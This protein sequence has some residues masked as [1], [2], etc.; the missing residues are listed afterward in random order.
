MNDSNERRTKPEGGFRLISVGAVLRCWEAYRE[1]RIKFRDLRVW[2][3]AQE[4]V[5]RR[6]TIGKGRVPSYSMDEL[7]RLVGGVGGEHFRV[8]M[9]RLEAS[10]VISWTTSA[11]TFP[12]VERGERKDRRL[13]PVPRRTLRFL[14]GCNRP[15]LS[16]T[17][18]GYL[19][20]CMFFRN[21]ECLSRGTCK[22][23]WVAETFRVNIR[24]V[25]AARKYLAEISWL[26]RAESD[27]WHKQRWGGTAIVNLAWP[28]L[29]GDG[30]VKRELPPR[31]SLSTTKLPPPE[32][33]NKLPS[34]SRNQ[35]LTV[36]ERSG[37]KN[38]GRE[39]P[40]IAN[41]QLE[42]LI[43]FSRTEALYRQAIAQGLV[44][45]SENQVLNWI[46]AAVRAKSVVGNPVRVFAGIVR[47]KLW[48]Y[49]TQEQEDHAR[50]ALSRYRETNPDY[51]RL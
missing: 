50:K 34:E 41:I 28:G 48:R 18:L 2:F 24:G 22:A 47:K 39:R 46:G 32:S 4:L 17:I 36:P 43:R 9:R 23:S 11:I 33:N 26:E 42:D 49:I 31:P 10:R 35:K 44:E 3:G 27:H 21:G 15:A 6:C 51:F 1:D 40:T 25:K 7:T 19:I 12:N 8:S 13:I 38:E 45:H 37:V 5:A 16:A 14:A 20:R 30:R 29:T